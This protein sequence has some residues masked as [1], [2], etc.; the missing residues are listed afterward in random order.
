LMT[1]LATL[2]AAVPPALALG[3]GAESRIPMAIT[4]IGGVLVSTFFTLLV[5]PCAYSLLVRLESRS[6]PEQELYGETVQ[7]VMRPGSGTNGMATPAA[8]GNGTSHPR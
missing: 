2:A 8:A 3:P 4:V 1:S 7:P 6:H 5:V